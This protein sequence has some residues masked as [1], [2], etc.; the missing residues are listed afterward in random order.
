MVP[1]SDHA[2]IREWAERNEAQP[3]QLHLRKVDGQSAKLTFLTGDP[4]QARPEI[5]PID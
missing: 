4:S 5:V 1:T 2:E 3:A